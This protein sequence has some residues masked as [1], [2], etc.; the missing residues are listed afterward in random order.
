M[1]LSKARTFIT[2]CFFVSG[3]LFAAA[4]IL[5]QG[6]Q[7][8]APAESA[9]GAREARLRVITAA[10]KYQGVRYRY[11]G[12]DN[13]GLDCSGFVYRSFR[14]ALSVS[15]PRTTGGLYAW[16]EKID[17]REMQAGDL[18]FF[19]TTSAGTVSHVGIYTGNGRFI[20]SASEGPET[21][22]IYSNL[23]EKYWNR[24]YTGAGRALPPETGSNPSG[25][26]EMAE[27]RHDGANGTDRTAG[28]DRAGPGTTWPGAARPGGGEREGEREDKDT[29]EF[30]IYRMG[31]GLAPSWNGFLKNGFPIRGAAGY[32]RVAAE[33]HAWKRPVLLGLELR[34]E[35]DNALGVFRLPVTFSLGFDD[36]IR[37]FFGP[38]FS[39]GDP[40]LHTAE[41]ERHYKGGTAWLGAAGVSAIPFLWNVKYGVLALYGELAW[42][43]YLSNSAG[44]NWNA[45]ICAGVRF[46]TGLCFNWN[47]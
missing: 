3:S 29:F 30:G 31:V 40:V 47:L 13:Q 15:V 34:P 39:F 7:A 17:D 16:V 10:E 43:S 14:D 2:A 4:P 35:W 21:G 22:V 46:S 25:V 1:F 44:R 42:Q 33:T 18:L 27:V 41:G 24:T 28:A 5:L 26:V 12:V 36:R 6:G 38:S 11:G 8:S 20:H 19:K 23:S 9:S 37:I 32:I 45:D